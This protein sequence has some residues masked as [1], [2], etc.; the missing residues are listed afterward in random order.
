M[1]VGEPYINR[2]LKWFLITLTYICNSSSRFK[3]AQAMLEKK[4]WCDICEK[5]F[6]YV[7]FVV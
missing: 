2:V 3:M 7:N 5:L 4:R 6:R 1:L